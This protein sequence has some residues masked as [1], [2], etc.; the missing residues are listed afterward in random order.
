MLTFVWRIDSIGRF[1]WECGEET[2]VQ[3]DRA[4]EQI[5]S[6]VALQA[7]WNVKCYNTVVNVVNSWAYFWHRHH[8]QHCHHY[9]QFIFQSVK[10]TLCYEKLP[11]NKWEKWK[12]LFDEISYTIV[13]RI[14]IS[15]FSFRRMNLCTVQ[16]TWNSTILQTKRYSWNNTK[17]F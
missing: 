17:L 9:N 15:L 13:L 5:K 2:V 16:F 1:N 10:L 14:Y 6:E 12:E 7:L 8:H 11:P 3:K 4:K